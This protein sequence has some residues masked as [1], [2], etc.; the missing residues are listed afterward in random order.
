MA[1]LLLHRFGV[2]PSQMKYLSCY[3]DLS[4][5]LNLGAGALFWMA[6]C[7]LCPCGVAQQLPMLSLGWACTIACL[8]ALLL[9]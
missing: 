9:M 2:G 8:S 1:A 4:I 6:C 5:R 7:T 3:F